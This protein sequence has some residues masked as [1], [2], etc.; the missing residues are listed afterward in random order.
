MSTPPTC[1][2]CAG[3]SAENLAILNAQIRNGEGYKLAHQ[4]SKNLG[5]TFSEWEV[6]KHTRHVTENAVAF[7]ERAV[8]ASVEDFG[9]RYQESADAEATPE[10]L[11]AKGVEIP[12][13]A[14][15]VGATI[16]QPFVS[17][18]VDE[19]GIAKRGMAHVRIKP[20]HEAGARIEIRQAMPVDMQLV[21]PAALPP[22]RKT[23]LKTAIIYPDL[24]A[25]YWIDNDGVRH[26]THDEA[27]NDV[28]LQIT[29]DLEAEH[30]IDDQVDLGDIDDLPS[31]SKHRSATSHLYHS[32]MNETHDRISEILYAR[33]LAAP[34]ARRRLL[35]GNHCM[36]IRTFAMDNAAPIVGIRRAKSP[37]L[38]ES[39]QPV[40][41]LPF[42]LRLDEVGWEQVGP[43]PEG[44]LWLSPN[45]RCIHGTVVKPTSGATNAAYLTEQQVSTIY[46]HTHRSGM[47]H[48]TVITKDG[49][50][51]FVAYSPG[52][53]C[54]TI[55]D[56]PSAK[57]G[58]DDWGQPGQKRGENWEQG[59]GIVFYDP[60]G[61]TVPTIEHVP[62]YNGRAV[63]RGR[64]YLARCDADGN[65]L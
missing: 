22:R 33:S 11:K 14:E 48:R 49:P 50:R 42:L 13:D 35:E 7:S 61:H 10:Y 39:E 65:P 63:W 18:I 45:L 15:F 64:E 44:V 58:Y 5:Y 4:S 30:G 28:A 9:E 55:G 16:S 57:G 32:A 54:K 38:P 47:D 12:D 2:V 40:L 60:E 31:V 24:Q 20:K 19:D 6:R 21:V 59:V 29:I 41:S 1:K 3:M 43:Y 53:L 25:W 56:V 34:R 27:A 26:T 17:D 37:L 51:T 46:G 23:D 62:I 36:R 52:C 8:G